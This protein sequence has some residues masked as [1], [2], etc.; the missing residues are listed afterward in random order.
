MERLYLD[1]PLDLGMRLAL[2]AAKAHYLTRVLRLKSGATIGV[3]DNAGQEWQAALE[4]SGR[5]AT[6]VTQAFLG[7]D[8]EPRLKITLAQAL[9]KQAKLEFIWQKACELGVARLIPLM[10]SHS[11]VKLDESKGE[12]K[13]ERWETVLEEA[14][15]Q[16]GRR[17]LPELLRPLAF[18]EFVSRPPVSG[19][20]WLA[21]EGQGVVPLARQL[22][23]TPPTSE[24]TLI[25]GPEGGFSP[26][27]VAIARGL[28]LPLVGLGPRVLRVE[29]AGLAAIAIV[30]AAVGDW[31]LE[32]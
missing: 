9:P 27:E 13:M 29:T 1:L 21:Y 23:L 12:R 14:C 30:Q 28:G 20:L 6:I 2:P 10:T 25:I 3:F 18:D 8:P 7:V 11:Q 5:E 4:L 24:L 26:Q 19:P 17:R 31:A 22:T 15:R 32:N 16:C